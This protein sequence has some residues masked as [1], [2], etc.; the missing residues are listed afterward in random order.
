MQPYT[1]LSYGGNCAQAFR[2]Y[3]QHLGGKIA[4]LRRPSSPTGSRCCGTV[5]HVLD[6][7]ARATAPERV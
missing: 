3:E 5:R 1:Y 2:F 7:P 4:V 6:A